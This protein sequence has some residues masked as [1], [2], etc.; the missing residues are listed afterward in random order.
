MSGEA[1]LGK[2]KSC[3]LDASSLTCLVADMAV[4]WDRR[5]HTW[6]FHVAKA[7]ALHEGLRVV[8]I[9]TW[10]LQAPKGIPENQREAD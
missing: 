7:S 1:H 6:P 9:P 8:R 2:L 5:A 10:Q 4:G 3:Y